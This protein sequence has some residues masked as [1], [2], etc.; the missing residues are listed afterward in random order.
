MS[1]PAHPLFARLYDPVMALPERLFL[2]GHRTYLADGLSGRVLDLGAGT[3]AMF[4][5]FERAPDGP[6]VVA[7]EPD[8]HMRRRAIERAADA[9]ADIEVVDAGAERLPDDGASFDAVVASFVFCTIP[10]AS[11][12]LDEVARVLRPGG[13][14]R[15]VEHVRARGPVG[16][17]HDAL[18]PGWYHAAGGCNLDRQTGDRFRTDD[19]FDLL[20]FRRFESGST[21]LL[22]VVRGRLERRGGSALSGLRGRLLSA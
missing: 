2:G 16:W 17:L 1:D 12:A 21:R 7:A 6:T 19:R 9:P 4:P 10:D 20:D 5:Y 3:G 15:F 18:A 14:F 13:E 8:P 11:G 22:P